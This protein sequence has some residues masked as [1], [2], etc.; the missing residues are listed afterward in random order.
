[1]KSV[2]LL[3]GLHSIAHS[4][5]RQSMPAGLRPQLRGVCRSRFRPP[6]PSGH[7]DCFARQP[8]PDVHGMPLGGGLSLTRPPRR[9]RPKN[10][11]RGNLN[12]AIRMSK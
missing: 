3:L 1:M 12:F 2:D 4:A 9:D 11:G 5:P 7:V 10:R 8:W 6:A